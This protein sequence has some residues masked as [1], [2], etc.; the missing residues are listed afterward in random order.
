M[1]KPA[2][3][4]ASGAVVGGDLREGEL[5]GR[6][7]RLAVVEDDRRGNADDDAAGQ[8]VAQVARH[9]GDAAGRHRKEDDGRAAAGLLVRDELVAGRPRADDHLLAD[10]AEPL[11]QALAEVPAAADDSDHRTASSTALPTS[12]LDSGATITMGATSASG[13]SPASAGSTRTSVATPA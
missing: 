8:G 2:T 13:S 1:W 10:P 11:G 12:A 9:V 4:R 5:P 3:T 7:A 6:G